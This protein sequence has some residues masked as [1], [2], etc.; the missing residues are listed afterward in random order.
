MI[1]QRELSTIQAR[2]L[3][4]N[5]KNFVRKCENTMV[6]CISGSTSTNND[7]DVDYDSN[8][9]KTRFPIIHYEQ[10]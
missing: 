7:H 6:D 8:G 5:L 1:R 3:Q 9:E 4:E 10:T 2:R